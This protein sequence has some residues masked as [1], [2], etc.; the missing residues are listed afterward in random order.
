M[1][2][3]L[4]GLGAGLIAALFG[5]GAFGAV[6]GLPA[7]L[8]EALPSRALAVAVIDADPV[9]LRA[10]AEREAARAR[11]RGYRRGS[12]DWV[13]GA[14]YASRDVAQDRRYDEWEISVQRGIRLPAKAEADRGLARLEESAARHAYADARHAAAIALLET[15]MEWREADGQ[16]RLAAAAAELAQNDLRIIEE[17]M[18]N[19]DASAADLDAARAAAAQAASGARMVQLEQEEARIAL[20]TRFPGLEL[21]PGNTALPQPA[22]PAEPLSI[23]GE[24]VVEHNHEIDLAAARA[25]L[26]ELQAQ[27]ARLE[28]HADPV[29][30]VRTVSERD[31]DEQSVGVFISIPLG[32]GARA[33][34]A[35]ERT[36]QAGAAAASAA[37]VRRNVLSQARILVARVS[38]SVDAWQSAAQASEASKSHRER[39][40]RGVTLG[41]VRIGDLLDARRRMLDAERT[42]LEARVVALSSIARLLLDAHAYWIDEDHQSV[43]AP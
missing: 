18:R 39:L 15:W 29:V 43:A 41:G 27:R 34:L 16:Q 26:A 6:A 13:A 4:S 20:E 5:S 1:S 37:E 25:R 2:R 23:W 35:D 7:S 28:R 9:V 19:G 38:G 12:H 10:D 3:R 14:G 33:S 31:G 30:G 32:S 40:Q 22:I 8:L 21:A 36:G 17:R 11:A 42:E 24:R